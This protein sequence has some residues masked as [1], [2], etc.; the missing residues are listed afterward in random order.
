MPSGCITNTNY[1]TTGFVDLS[2]AWALTLAIGVC[3]WTNTFTVDYQDQYG[4]SLPSQ[5]V[6]MNVEDCSKID[7][8]TA[9]TGSIPYWSSTVT[10]YYI[11]GKTAPVSYDL[12]SIFDIHASCNTN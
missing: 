8:L 9:A 10:E 1:P 7:A 3:D 2:G 11:Y 5:T 6:T 4:S 12:H